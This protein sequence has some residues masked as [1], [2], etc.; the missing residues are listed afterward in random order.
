MATPPSSLTAARLRNPHRS[1]QLRNHGT[2][3]LLEQ[4]FAVGNLD[5]IEYWIDSGVVPE[6]L[7]GKA[8]SRRVYTQSLMDCFA[9]AAIW[10]SA[11]ENK[12]RLRMQRVVE[13]L[14]EGG[15]KQHVE[16]YD[17][18]LHAFMA[19]PFADTLMEHGAN[20]WSR[21]DEGY[22]S[23]TTSSVCHAMYQVW[24]NR[25]LRAVEQVQDEMFSDSLIE[26]ATRIDRCLDHPGHNPK[27]LNE[28]LAQVMTGMLQHGYTKRSD[29]LWRGWRERLLA[30]GATATF[31]EYDALD[32]LVRAAPDTPLR[33]IDIW[34]ERFRMRQAKREAIRAQEPAN[35]YRY[36]EMP[37]LTAEEDRKL[38]E[39]AR[40]R[41]AMRWIKLAH[42]WLDVL[43][44]GLNKPRSEEEIN[45]TG[46]RGS[47]WP[48]G[49]V[50][51][52]DCAGGTEVGERLVALLSKRGQP[53]PWHNDPGFSRN[54][55]EC[56]NMV[57][58]FE[59]RRSVR[60]M[61][62]LLRWLACDNTERGATHPAWRTAMAS[63]WLGYSP[64]V[65]DGQVPGM[66][67]DLSDE[68]GRRVEWRRRPDNETFLPSPREMDQL[69]QLAGPGAVQP[70]T[71]KEFNWIQGLLRDLPRLWA[72]DDTPLEQRRVLLEVMDRHDVLGR[73]MTGL[74]ILATA[75]GQ[76]DEAQESVQAINA[77]MAAWFTGWVK[78]QDSQAL[79]VQVLEQGQTT[80]RHLGLAMRRLSQWT[81]LMGSGQEFD[82]FMSQPTRETDLVQQLAMDQDTRTLLGRMA[83]FRLVNMDHQN[84]QSTLQRVR[85]M[86][87][88]V[89]AGW[90]PDDANSICMALLNG[91]PK[92]AVPRPTEQEL[93]KDLIDA[94]ADD[95]EQVYS[96]LLDKLMRADNPPSNGKKEWAHLVGLLAHDGLTFNTPLDLRANDLLAKAVG[97][98]YDRA[99]LVK[100]A[101][102]ARKPEG[103]GV[104]R[105]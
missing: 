44:P 68:P 25:K 104:R 14:W 73:I 97:T 90:K 1:T 62:T 46:M 72:R 81:K 96:Q 60:K 103:P 51:L 70:I 76:A 15:A 24:A 92:H 16:R 64:S 40:D 38:A 34:D 48:Q 95:R 9:R 87:Q 30:M 41:R 65:D 54:V 75:K 80:H 22:L 4:S 93:I 99:E 85:G 11:H 101:D 58:I 32:V 78:D 36:I 83:T 55:N 28:A 20:P 18:W 94:I 29:Q 61:E 6:A 71:G 2:V 27:A 100:M 91:L 53:L 13:T 45:S 35:S 56:A 49:W 84:A 105:M 19:L 98:A 26:L 43:T 12:N 67:L 33:L 74:G 102:A 17:H 59:Q 79:L 57:T 77:T 42:E 82:Q 89:A 23:D 10:R 31:N 88:L 39:Q 86:Y 21:T 8:R 50:K 63:A 52:A 7:A 37:E 3:S 66:D 5:E 47:H 69:L